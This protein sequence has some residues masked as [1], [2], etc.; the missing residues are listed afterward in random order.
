MSSAKKFHV[1]ATPTTDEG[2][3]QNIKL[4]LAE[5]KQQAINICIDAGYK[6]IEETEGGSVDQ[7]DAEDAP[8]IYSFDDDGIGAISVTVKDPCRLIDWLAAMRSEGMDDGDIAAGLQN[9]NIPKPDWMST[10]DNTYH[11]KI[12]DQDYGSSQMGFIDL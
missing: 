2:F 10:Q 7:Y 4:G 1:L 3:G 12:W 9:G 8:F 11:T 6:V 5:T